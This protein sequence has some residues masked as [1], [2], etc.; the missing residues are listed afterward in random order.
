MEEMHLTH[1]LAVVKCHSCLLM[2][3]KVVRKLS[4]TQSLPVVVLVLASLPFLFLV[5]YCWA[6]R[7]LSSSQVK[8][9]YELGLILRHECA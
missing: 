5:S 4:P 2:E 1:R 6:F 7:F 9:K 3:T 8:I